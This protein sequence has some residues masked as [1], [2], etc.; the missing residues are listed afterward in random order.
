[1]HARTLLCNADANA[2]A[3]AAAVA[4]CCAVLR[5]QVA[6]RP[7]NKDKLIAV[8]LPSFGERCVRGWSLGMQL[9]ACMPPLVQPALATNPC[10]VLLLS[11]QVPEQR[12]VPEHP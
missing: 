4:A 11:L 8:V 12:A 1:M 3:A 2:D 7:E 6:K 10:N 5:R 9:P